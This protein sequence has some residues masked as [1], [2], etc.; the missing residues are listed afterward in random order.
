[1]EHL[2]VEGPNHLF[3]DRCRSAGA[4]VSASEPPEVPMFYQGIRF[5]IVNVDSFLRQN[6][7]TL[8]A[9]KRKASQN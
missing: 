3:C 5:G 2:H 7:Q 8:A 6:A 9:A 1:M 4:N